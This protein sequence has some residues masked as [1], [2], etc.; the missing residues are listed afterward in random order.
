MSASPQQMEDWFF[1]VRPVACAV[2]A[3]P[4]VVAAAVDA[5]HQAQA[6]GRRKALEKMFVRA[7]VPDAT[8]VIN[9]LAGTEGWC[10]QASCPEPGGAA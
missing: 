4:D 5:V 2:S 6:A 3:D 8:E 10:D 7:G 1:A 9:R